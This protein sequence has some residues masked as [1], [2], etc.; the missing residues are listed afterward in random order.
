MGLQTKQTKNPITSSSNKDCSQ[1]EPNT[2]CSPSDKEIK[3]TFQCLISDVLQALQ[4]QYF[5][6]CRASDTITSGYLLMTT[7]AVTSS[8]AIYRIVT[9]QFSIVL[10]V[11]IF[12][13]VMIDPGKCWA[14]EKRL[15]LA[16]CRVTARWWVC[17]DDCVRLSIATEL[18]WHY[19]KCI[20]L[21]Y[22]H[23]HTSVCSPVTPRLINQCKCILTDT[24]SFVYICM[25]THMESLCLRYPGSLSRGL[26]AQILTLVTGDQPNPTLASSALHTRTVFRLPDQK[27]RGSSAQQA[28]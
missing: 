3:N 5:L 1:T 8:T 18:Y 16:H 22:L 27:W 26:F 28:V 23:T 4:C 19:C 21:Q 17:A 6:V 14:N 9:M 7:A 2:D 25:H 13:D 24:L 11:C 12:Q 20:T 10:Y 15:A